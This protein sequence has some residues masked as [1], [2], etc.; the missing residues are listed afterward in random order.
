MVLEAANTRPKCLQAWFLI[1][2]FFFK[3]HIATFLLN[4]HMFSPNLFIWGCWES[5]PGL[6]IG[7]ASALLSNST[8]ALNILMLDKT[9]P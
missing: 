5:N 1:V 8:L 2:I 7:K 4:P 6:Y 3:L 9:P